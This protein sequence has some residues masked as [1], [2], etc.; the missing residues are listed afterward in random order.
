MLLVS[1]FPDESFS[2]TVDGGMRPPSPTKVGEMAGPGPPGTTVGVT[3]SV[4]VRLSK[5]LAVG[6]QDGKQPAR[7]S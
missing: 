4:V 7:N 3:I 1:T 6:G 2:I 5:S